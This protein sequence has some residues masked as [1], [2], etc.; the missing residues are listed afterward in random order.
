MIQ[1]LII[2]FVFLGIA[3]P[4]IVVSQIKRYRRGVVLK[5]SEK[6]KKLLELNNKYTFPKARTSWHYVFHC[7]NLNKFRKMDDSMLELEFYNNNYD[8]VLESLNTISENIKKYNEY[9]KIFD[10]IRNS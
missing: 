4:I 1:F 5:T 3:T 2:L 10:E 6:R 8:D 7:Q 9:S